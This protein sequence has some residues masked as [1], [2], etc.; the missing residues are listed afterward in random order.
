[1]FSEKARTG[2]GNEVGGVD[3]ARSDQRHSSGQ[4]GRASLPPLPCINSDFLKFSGWSDFHESF[5]AVKIQENI[6][7]TPAASERLMLVSDDG[8]SRDEVAE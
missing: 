1:M 2:A 4:N 6:P 8:H 3:L 5:I 7:V